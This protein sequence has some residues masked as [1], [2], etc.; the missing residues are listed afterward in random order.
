MVSMLGS[1]DM[2]PAI[3]LMIMREMFC[4]N[5][6]ASG[7]HAIVDA[8]TDERLVNC[9]IGSVTHIRL[10]HCQVGHGDAHK[11]HPRLTI[12]IFPDNSVLLGIQSDF[13]CPF[14]STAL[15]FDCSQ[16][17]CLRL[18]RTILCL[19]GQTCLLHWVILVRDHFSAE[20]LIG[21]LSRSVD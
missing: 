12:R 19:H 15:T 10:G 2:L 16:L 21:V 6:E 13:P 9:T 18:C 17:P 20:C 14:A 11:Y 5:T 1:C 7:Q 4:M 3:W 8:K